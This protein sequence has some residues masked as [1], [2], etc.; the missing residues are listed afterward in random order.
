[1]RST[2]RSSRRSAST[3][4][5]QAMNPLARPS[6]TAAAT[7]VRNPRPAARSPRASSRGA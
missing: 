7:N 2:G 5:C 4:G 6:G 3:R 1:V